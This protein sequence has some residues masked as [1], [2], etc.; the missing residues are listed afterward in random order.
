[1]A[2]EEEGGDGEAGGSVLKKWGPLAAIVLAVQVVFT[3][4]LVSFVPDLFNNDKEKEQE[5][6][7][8]VTD[9]AEV[10]SNQGESDEGLPFYYPGSFLTNITANPAGT[11][12]ERFLVFDLELGLKG[13]DGEEEHPGVD[14]KWDDEN[15]TKTFDKF[16]PRIKSIVT[17]IMRS[18]TV[19]QLEGEFLKDAKQEMK[20]RLN[21]EIFVKIFK[22]K[23]GDCFGCTGYTI[24]V[25]DVNISR[26]VIQ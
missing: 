13:A 14:D 3:W 4:A 20:T 12:G 2:E 16:M 17:E 15:F 22:Q 11:N 10:V 23:K 7:P 25:E 9:R 6:E 8:L 26:L 18:K 5:D 1:M 21:Q 24:T 19:N